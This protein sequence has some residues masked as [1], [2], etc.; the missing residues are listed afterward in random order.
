[1]SSDQ[2]SRRNN[3]FA[4]DR[5]T[6]RELGG[7]SLS[8]YNHARLVL[9]V[10]GRSPGSSHSRTHIFRSC[11]PLVDPPWIHKLPTSITPLLLCLIRCLSYIE[12]LSYRHLACHILCIVP[13]WIQSP[14]PESSGSIP[15]PRIRKCTNSC[16]Q[17][18]KITTYS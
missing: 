5:V 3:Q 18:T 17:S 10:R 7:G 16:K 4:R 11:I 15:I 9:L 2:V 8:F 14:S 13:K 6:C 12:N 1:M